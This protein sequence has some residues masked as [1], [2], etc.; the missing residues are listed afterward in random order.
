MILNG[1]N[2]TGDLAI[3]GLFDLGQL[4]S[5]N[6]ATGQLAIQQGTRRG[7]IYFDQGQIVN[8]IDENQGEGEDAAYR[9][10]TWKAGSFEF[11]PEGV[12]SNRLIQG[13]TESVMLEAARRIDES[14]ESDGDVPRVTAQLRARAQSMEALRDTF[15]QLANEARGSAARARVTSGSPI[16]ALTAADDRL[17]FRRNRPPRL[18]CGGQW[19]SAS[20]T[21]IAAHEYADIRKQLFETADTLTGAPPAAPAPGE[22]AAAI[23]A[24]SELPGGVE[25]RIAR[26]GDGRAFAATVVGAGA[27]EALWVRRVAL[28]APDTSKLSGP[29]DV[30]Q[31]LLETPNGRLIVTAPDV[32]A[33]GELLHAVIAFTIRRAPA[34]ALVI[35][36]PPTYVHSEES[37]VITDVTPAGAAAALRAI[38]PTIVAI[39]AGLALDRET[40]AAL[41]GAGIVLHTVVAADEDNAVERLRD[42]MREGGAGSIEPD[43]LIHRSDSGG[44]AS[45][46]FLA[47]RLAAASAEMPA[48]LRATPRAA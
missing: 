14:G 21:P 8:A 45:I 20:E 33:A 40:W 10:F 6:G 7:I 19:F 3:I 42:A 38:R 28:E 9:L 43:G 11:K 22:S 37:G 31:K 15:S 24:A 2:F 48:P 25:T 13:G 4:L 32:F 17:I 44:V 36:A 18:C 47:R 23:P 34:A 39:E 35:A 16:D 12:T 41:E 30:L 29:L 46:R 5:L 26:F 1:G 27:E